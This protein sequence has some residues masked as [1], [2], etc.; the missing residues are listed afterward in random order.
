[1]INK[2]VSRKHKNVQKRTNKKVSRKHKNVQKRSRKIMRGGMYGTVPRMGK[3]T[4]TGGPS[5]LKPLPYSQRFRGNTLRRN[6]FSHKSMGLQN[7]LYET[8]D[9]ESEQTYEKPFPQGFDPRNYPEATG[10]LR[11]GSE[12]EYAEVGERSNYAPLFTKAQAE[13]F[14]AS[15]KEREKRRGIPLPLLPVNINRRASMTGE[16]AESFGP[17]VKHVKR[18]LANPISFRLK[19]ES[20]SDVSGNEGYNKR[21]IV[22]SRGKII[23]N[24]R[25]SGR[26]SGRSS[27]SSP[28]SFTSFTRRSSGSS[29]S[30]TSGYE[31][32][33]G[34][35]NSD[36]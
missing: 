21:V 20:E 1:M 11:R 12:N 30:G 10:T 25:S 9:S 7:P 6:D 23:D 2:K 14:S 18:V 29:G 22:N 31:T 26:S 19:T 32:D 15:K 35:Y 34:I 33:F 5:V 24:S 27:R 4:T 36:G 3:P 17:T 16:L 13:A 8:S 28:T